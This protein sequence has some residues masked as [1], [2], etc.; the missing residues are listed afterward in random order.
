MKSR[1]LVIIACLSA[2]VSV[3]HLEAKTFG[4]FN[5]G[6]SFDLRVVRVKSTKQTGYSGPRLTNPI[7]KGVPRYGVGSQLHFVIGAQGVLRTKGL[8]VPLAHFS[9]TE[10]EYNLF[11]NGV[12][13]STTRNAE[14]TKA[15]GNATG[16]TLSFFITDNSGMEPIFYTVVYTLN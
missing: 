8:S 7:P 11:R 9:Q 1:I 2:L 3:T 4:G 13:R 5:V 14:I 6:D 15:R 16:G 10:N 12:V